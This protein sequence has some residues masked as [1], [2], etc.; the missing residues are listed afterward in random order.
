VD[1]V[2]CGVVANEGFNVV[3]GFVVKR[4]ARAMARSTQLSWGSVTVCA[5][6]TSGVRAQCCVFMSGTSFTC[7]VYAL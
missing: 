6:L 2:W 4:V 5:D 3:M 7:I 1:V